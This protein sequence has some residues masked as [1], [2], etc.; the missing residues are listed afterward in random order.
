MANARDIWATMADAHAV[1]YTG[2]SVWHV[3]DG[4]IVEGWPYPDRTAM[5]AQRAG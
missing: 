4:R 2:C 1:N 3:A 5:Q